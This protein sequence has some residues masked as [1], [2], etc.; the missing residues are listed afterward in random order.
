MTRDEA[1]RER[2]IKRFLECEAKRAEAHTAALAEGKTEVDADEAGDEAAKHHWN[3]WAEDMLAQRKTLKASGTWIPNA[4]TRRWLVEAKTDFSGCRFFLTTLEGTEGPSEENGGQPAAEELYCKSIAVEGRCVDFCGFIFPGDTSFDSATFSGHTCFDSAK[5]SGSAYFYKATFE[6]YAQFNRATFGGMASFTGAAFKDYA[7]FSEATFENAG[8]FE[9]TTFEDN[10][11]FTGTT[12]ESFA[13]FF[14]AA[15]EG[16]SWFDRAI[17]E[18]G[19]S[20]DSSTFLGDASFDSATFKGTTAYGKATFEDTAR[21][22]RAT[23]EGEASLA[24]VSFEGGASF[25]SST[26]LKST[27]FHGAK[28]GSDEKKADAHFTAIK[29]DRAFNLTAA[30]FS[31]VPSFCQ[32]DFKQAPDLDRVVFPVPPAEPLTSGDEDLIPKYRAIRRMAIQSADYDREQRAFKGEMRSRRWKIDK[33]RHPEGFF[34]W[35]YDW[36]ADCGRSIIRPSA[37]WLLSVFV[38]AVLYLPTGKNVLDRCVL[39]DGSIFV[40]SLYISGRNALVL[41]SGGKDDRIT[42]AYQC[43]FGGTIPDS[44]SFVESFVQ[45]PLSAVLIFLF[46]L[47][48]KNRFKI[49]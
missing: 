36:A 20:F 12:F 34:G 40:K 26:F 16:N 42:K 45:V 21:F 13:S 43:L 18:G 39:G 1:A 37:I 23:F 41:S 5:F 15:F 22:E 44:V 11:S 24:G 27:S 6:T 2:T 7:S 29:V 46:L 48:V 25:D 8:E 28:F 14:R 35:C 38:F 33:F 47:A 17:F 49:K 4:E 9:W 10:A 31:K 32:A 30:R 19:A 3:A